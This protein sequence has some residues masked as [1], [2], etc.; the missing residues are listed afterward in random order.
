[1]RSKILLLSFALSVTAGLAG[2]ATLSMNAAAAIP[3][4]TASLPLTLSGSDAS[5]S[6]LQWT[7]NYSS[8]DISHIDIL[9]GPAGNAAAKDLTCVQ[10]ADGTAACLLA[11]LNQN[12]ISDG[13]IATA[14][15]TLS[16]Q[17]AAS[18]EI[19]S[20]TGTASSSGDGLPVGVDASGSAVTLVSPAPSV[21]PPSA[22]SVPSD[23]I[24]P[25][26]PEPVAPP[27]EAPPA[28][29]SRPAVARLT[30][31]P[32]A[33]VIPAY[34][35]CTVSLTSAAPSGG[36]AVTL[37]YA[38]PDLRVA[39]PPSVL[40]PAG[41]MQT[42]FRMGVFGSTAAS[43]LLLSATLNGNGPTYSLRVSLP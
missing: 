10:V 43:Q 13:V 16:P 25:P 28:P 7:L 12:V 21:T 1:L 9:V 35:W 27:P 2:S 14:V 11:G 33:I 37:A 3:G 41:A 17:T 29:P 32:S 30:C 18:S 23:P 5:I 40:V 38:A 22:P 26:A 39:L 34:T 24:P 6:T 4:G 36:T 31:S 19:V 15:L 8:S 42:T 20:V